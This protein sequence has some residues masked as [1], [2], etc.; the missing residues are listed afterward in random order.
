VKTGAVI[1]LKG[2]VYGDEFITEVNKNKT[3]QRLLVRMLINTFFAVLM[4]ML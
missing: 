4:K 1:A 2:T 3:Y